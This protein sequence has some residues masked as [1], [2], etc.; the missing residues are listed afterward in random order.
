[1]FIVLSRERAFITR[2]YFQPRLVVADE[3]RVACH[4]K[5]VC[6]PVGIKRL[7]GLECCKDAHPKA[8]T[9]NSATA[10]CQQNMLYGVKPC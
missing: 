6:V 2:N 9:G 10:Q 8:A 3:N 4:N 1:M 7:A 5:S